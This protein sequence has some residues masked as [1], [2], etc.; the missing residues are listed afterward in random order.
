MLK[1]LADQGAN[2]LDKWVIDSAA[3]SGNLDI[4]KWINDNNGI[5][6]IGEKPRRRYI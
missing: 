2:I 6:K 3:R 1:W 5:S 4:V